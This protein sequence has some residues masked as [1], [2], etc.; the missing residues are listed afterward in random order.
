METKTFQTIAIT[1]ILETTIATET[2]TLGSKGI[3][4]LDNKIK[5]IPVKVVVI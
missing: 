5:M 4:I 3:E 1:L 2:T